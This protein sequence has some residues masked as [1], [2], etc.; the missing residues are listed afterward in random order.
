MQA[1]GGRGGRSGEA[2][3]YHWRRITLES[4]PVLLG[5]VVIGVGSGQLLVAFEDRLAAVPVLLALVPA[6]NGIGGNVGSVLGSRVASGLHFGSLLSNRARGFRRDVT[7][8]LLL[9]LVVFTFLGLVAGLLG[10]WLGLDVPVHVGRL[11]AATLLAGLGLMVVMIL[12]VIVVGWASY[13]RGWDPD[14]VVVPVLTTA[15]D[16][17]GILFLLAAAAVVEI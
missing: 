14:N 5:A 12:L 8:S 16:T 15:G 6:V 3:S 11:A 13:R 7:A 9:T 10:P 1:G 4:L 17:L 2:P